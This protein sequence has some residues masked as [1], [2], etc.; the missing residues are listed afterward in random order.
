MPRLV[1]LIRRHSSDVIAFEPIPMF[2]RVLRAVFEGKRGRIDDYN[3]PDVG[4]IKIDI[5]GHELGVLDGAAAT[6]A[7]QY[8]KS[9]DLVQR[10][11]PARR[12][13][14]AGRLA[15]RPRILGC[16]RRWPGAAPDRSVPA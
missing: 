15:G 12:G 4:F 8:A 16:V 13:Q 6:L 10:R 11:A 14:A 9:P 2:N 7:R 5:E 1:F 3:L